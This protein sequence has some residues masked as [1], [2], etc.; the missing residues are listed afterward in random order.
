MS[1]Y[2]DTAGNMFQAAYDAGNIQHAEDI[3]LLAIQRYRNYLKWLQAHVL[4]VHRETVDTFQKL[5]E[6][7]IAGKVKD[8]P[9]LDPILG[10]FLISDLHELAHNVGRAGMRLRG[11]KFV[12]DNPYYFGDEPDDAIIEALRGGLSEMTA[13]MMVK[14]E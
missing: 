11:G 7:N 8:I 12:L 5:L 9:R 2:F 4:K 6:H 1:S 13:R 3:M 14:H 10:Q